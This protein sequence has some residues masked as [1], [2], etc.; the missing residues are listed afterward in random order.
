[1]GVTMDQASTLTMAEALDSLPKVELHCHVEGTMRPETLAELAAKSGRELGTADSRDLYRYNSLDGFLKVFW[2]AQSCLTSR[3][4]WARLAYESVVDGA[5]H[6][7]VYRENFFTPARH[8]AAGQD[9]EDV[10]L[11]LEDGLAAGEAETGLT[12]MLGERPRRD[13]ARLVFHVE[14]ARLQG[15]PQRSD[16]LG[17][18][19]RRE[20]VEPLLMDAVGD[21]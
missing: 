9:L 20:A 13:V 10:M 12:V 14:A 7:L 3:D 17:I 5:A 19:G 8:L 21:P 11:A 18:R 4:D 6:G 16:P 1:M 15:C 2:L